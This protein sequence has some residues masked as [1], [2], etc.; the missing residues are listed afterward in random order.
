MSIN[1]KTWRTKTKI[2]SVADARG[3]VI[4]EKIAKSICI[5][6][7]EIGNRIGLKTALC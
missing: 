7:C 2:M 6:W 3:W 4:L 5:V 1:M